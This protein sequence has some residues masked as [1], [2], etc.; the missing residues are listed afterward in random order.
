VPLPSVQ[1]S[2]QTPLADS[3][4][5][6]GQARIAFDGAQGVRMAAQ[7]DAGVEQPFLEVTCRVRT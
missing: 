1:D 7:F 5:S 4:S 3:F 2:W 6:N